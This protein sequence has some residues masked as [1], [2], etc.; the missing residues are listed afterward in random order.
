MLLAEYLT[1]Y[2]TVFPCLC[3]CF[4]VHLS[5]SVYVRVCRSVIHSGDT[6]GRGRLLTAKFH[7]GD[8]D[9][10]AS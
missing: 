4:C 7:R 2:L 1:N 9:V 6:D 3:V 10:L 8:F 5:E